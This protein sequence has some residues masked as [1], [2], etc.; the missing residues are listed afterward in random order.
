MNELKLT[1]PA[2][3]E[4]LKTDFVVTKS[5]LAFCN[6]FV[7]QGLE[8][9]IKEL[10]RYG[11]L[12]GI[13]QDAMDRFVIT[14]PHLAKYVEMFLRGFPKYSPT[15]QTPDVYHQ[16][17]GNVSLRC[18]I[19]STRIRDIIVSFCQ[20]N[21]FTKN[22]RLMHITSGAII[23]DKPADDILNYP[24]KGQLRYDTLITTRLLPGSELSIW[25]TLPQLKLKRFSTWMKAKR[26][27]VGNKV[28]KLKE[29][30]KLLS[31][32]LTTA[33][34]RPDLLSKMEDIVGKYE[35]S[36]IPR[37]NFSPDGAMLLTADK[38]SLMKL[39]N[40]QTPVQ[41]QIPVAEDKPQVLIIDAMPEVRCLKK[42]ATTT[43]LGHLKEAFIQRIK[44]KAAKGRYT[45]IYVAFD[46][47]RDE[48]L[49]DKTRAKRSIATAS[50][51][52]SSIPDGSG[53]DMH[54]GMC[55]KKTSVADLLA[56]N[57]SKTQMAAYLAKGLLEE[58]RR[59]QDVR[60]VVTHSGLIYIN[61]PH[62]LP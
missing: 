22:T 60:L 45:E 23:P 9:E 43:K 25:D 34:T 20:G 62:T 28:I 5:T 36:I 12:P 3:W 38:A 53:F 50:T 47:W 59:N 30:R 29:D 1:D 26:V 55:L 58:Y 35:M 40:D 48:S 44:W 31:K 39:V 52:R 33:K 6:L 37:A 56:T 46:E 41:V 11:H 21:P 4:R 49:K 14:S 61:N 32:I 24:E 19:N 17:K 7:D 8:Q 2:T 16:L 15:D 54:D 13:T 51:Q 27:K 42:R 10:K 18:A 57:T